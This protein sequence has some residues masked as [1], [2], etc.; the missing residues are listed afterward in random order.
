M[1]VGNVGST[2]RFDYTLLGDNV[3]L[4]SRLEGLSKKYGVTSIVAESVTQNLDSQEFLFRQLDE[5]KVKGK[6]KAI[7]M[8][9]PLS[10]NAENQ[11]LINTFTQ[12]FDLYQKGDFIKA[13]KIFAELKND[14]VSKKYLLRIENL[15]IEQ[16]SV[17]DGIWT[18]DEK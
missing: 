2:K 14:P 4:G 15:T 6:D 5:A 18:W 9:E 12:A 16:K 7:K 13:K 1:I 8:Y 17:W 11:N 10:K 3:N